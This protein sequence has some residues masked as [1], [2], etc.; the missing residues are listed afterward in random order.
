MGD[1]RQSRR[2]FLGKALAAV[3]VAA[4]NPIAIFIDPKEVLA[5]NNTFVIDLSLAKYA[6]L[7]D[8]AKHYSI[9]IRVLTQYREYYGVNDVESLPYAF[10]VT[11]TSDSPRTYAAV[12]GYCSHKG[13]GLVL[14]NGDSAYNG[15]MIKCPNPDPGHGSTYNVQGGI[16]H[17]AGAPYQKPLESYT[18]T[19]NTANNT[20]EV[21][22]PGL[23]VKDGQVII[24]DPD[25]YQNFPNPATTITAIRFRLFYYSKVTLTV[26][27]MLGQIIAILHDGPLPQGEYSFDFNTSIW[28]SGIYFYHLNANGEIQSKQMTVVH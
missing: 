11:K 24:S 7:S 26:S 21:V 6:N 8:P 16:I 2:E 17:A 12:Q 9:W 13:Y 10:L 14:F 20:V 5:A 28:A 27:D 25:L 4:I 15:Q 1:E 19:Y 3:A 22:I 23:G 18:A